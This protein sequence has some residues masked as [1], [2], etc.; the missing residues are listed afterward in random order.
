MSTTKVVS[1]L[2]VA[3][4]LGVGAQ[5]HYLSGGKLSG[6]SSVGSHVWTVGQDGLFFYSEDN[7]AHWRRIP[8]FTTRNLFDVEFRDAVFGLITTDCG[9]VY[10][11]TNNG[12]T[13]DSMVLANSDSGRVRF[14]DGGVIWITRRGFALRS[15]DGGLSWELRTGGYAFWFA[16]SLNGWTDNVRD[17][18]R[19]SDAGRTWTALGALPSEV[20]AVVA[21]AFS[22]ADFGVC[23]VWL[24][25]SSPARHRY[26]WFVTE[27][28]GHT[29]SDAS[30]AW[31]A[32]PA[33]CVVD[34]TGRIKAA[35]WYG[36][37][38][39]EGGQWPTY[40][41]LGYYNELSDFS[42]TGSA[43]WICGS[44]GLAWSSS[45]GGISWVQGRRGTGKDIKELRF[46]DT[47]R[48]WAMGSRAL[49]KTADQ[50]RTWTNALGVGYEGTGFGGLAVMGHNTA[51]V[52]HDDLVRD[53]YGN[54]SGSCYFQRTTD[55][56]V[57][58]TVL[59]SAQNVG[60]FP[61]RR[62]TSLYFTDSLHGWHIGCGRVGTNCV[63]TSDGGTT[64]TDTG[65]EFNLEPTDLLF[66]DTLC[67]WFVDDRVCRTSNAGDSW[68]V[69]WPGRQERL[70][71]IEMVDPQEGWLTAPSGLS[72]TT[73][74]GSSWDSISA[75]SLNKVRF[76]G[77]R[78]G[79]AVAP[80]GLILRTSDGGET[81]TQD[82]CEF[83]SDLYDVFVLD[84]THAWAVGENGL[85]LG[86]GD[87]AVGVDEY[88]TVGLGR[89]RPM[90]WSVRPNPCR[91]LASIE[92]ARPMNED[93]RLAV[94]DAAGRRVRD[95][96]IAS[97][98]K[99]AVV[100]LRGSPAGVYFL[101]VRGEQTS[102]RTRLVR[103]E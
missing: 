44:G 87:W 7:G 41:Y 29:W 98:A 55:G 9:V 11:T 43:Y 48:G 75:Q 58:W 76:L 45:D 56:G 90:S 94:F 28:G 102:P 52:S 89:S 51:I 61:P 66:L 88:V 12:A 40:F 10:R 23:E 42:V 13:W 86:Y 80:D 100:D 53:R 30:V 26:E 49:Q 37:R 20:D 70:T 22:N 2:C 15:L 24:R 19:T 1:L 68:E 39:F 50:G 38:T 101:S 92:L 67:G 74:G 21:M 34:G 4:T 25:Y 79:V 57:H 5:W 84:S 64:W 6:I 60:N 17:I 46:S 95:V 8:R 82:S 99:S 72:H 47:L 27:D 73:D 71:S 62:A 32:T 18:W 69:A 14:L 31:Y 3:V 35:E 83:T 78:Q 85:V 96:V 54:Y 59:F 81:W 93:V 91:G 16:D 63:R 103:T 33:V 36:C 77:S 97:G 65:F